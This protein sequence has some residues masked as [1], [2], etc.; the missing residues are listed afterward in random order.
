MRALP[1][2]A[3]ALVLTACPSGPALHYTT[4]HGVQMV[5][6][7]GVQ[8]VPRAAEVDAWVS[9]VA[10]RIAV[11]D[12]DE[13]PRQTTEQMLAR[14]GTAEQPGALPMLL[15]W[16]PGAA[17][18]TDGRHVLCGSPASCQHEIAHV[19]VRMLVPDEPWTQARQEEILRVCEL[20]P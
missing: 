16:M 5:R 3:F 10:E 17:P 14:L 15:Y 18:Y 4:A 20:N 11:A 1:I 2:T 6:V 8:Q 9:A 12:C 13:L 19:L 7:A